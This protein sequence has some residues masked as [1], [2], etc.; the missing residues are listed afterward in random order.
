LPVHERLINP[1]RVLRIIPLFAKGRGCWK[2]CASP[3]ARVRIKKTNKNVARPDPRVVHEHDSTTPHPIG[4][5]EP[6]HERR[7]EAMP[8]ID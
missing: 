7:W 3:P 6:V 4:D 2:R 8:A 1:L 5:V